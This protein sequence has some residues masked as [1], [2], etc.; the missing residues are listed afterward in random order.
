MITTK[1]LITA[2]GLFGAV[3]AQTNVDLNITHEFNG[4]PFVYGQTYTNFDGKA[5]KFNRV[6]YYL[7]SFELTHDG[8]QSTPLT[9]VYVLGSGNITNYPLGTFNLTSL[10]S[11]NFDLGLDDAVNSGNTSNYTLPHPL[12]AQ[13]PSMD[14]SW[15][16][17]YFYIVM[18][19]FVDSNNDGTPDTEFQFHGLNK[20]NAVSVT[21]ESNDNAGQMDIEI[22]A[23]IA[24]WIKDIDLVS[25]GIQHNGG[26][27]IGQIGTNTNTYGVF[28]ALTSTGV[29]ELESSPNQ[30]IVDYTMAY[31]PTIY[32]SLNTVSDLQIIVTDLSGKIVLSASNLHNEG[33]FFINKELPDGLYIATFIDSKNL[34]ESIKFA[35]K[36]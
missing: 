6:Q 26:P 24:D 36:N 30:I 19:G 12:A 16:A 25:Q 14:W 17:G 7:S 20:R 35:I 1:T 13:T 32:Y 4:E 33:N 28:S 2:L 5:V 10:E 11:I 29:G 9:D 18:D 27:V 3:Q 23:N 21:T 34:K 15:P 31:A 8:G 22:F